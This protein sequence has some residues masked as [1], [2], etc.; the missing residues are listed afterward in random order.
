MVKRPSTVVC[1]LSR[2]SVL[3]SYY[4]RAYSRRATATPEYHEHY[5]VSVSQT[6][7]GD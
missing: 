5:P 2:C 1:Q 6:Q 4:R 7:V 3:L